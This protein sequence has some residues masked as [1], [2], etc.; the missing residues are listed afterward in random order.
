MAHKFGM[1]LAV[2]LLAT[3]SLT[4]MPLFEGATGKA[5]AQPTANQ[6]DSCT[7]LATSKLKAVTI[8][9]ATKIEAGAEVPKSRFNPMFGPSATVAKGLPAFCRV[10]G[11][12][13]PE[14]GSEIG[15]EVWF[16]QQQA[17]DG[18][19]HGI[20]IGGFAGVIDYFALGQAIKA[21]QVGVATNTGHNGS[22][23]DHGWAKGHPQRVT[24]Y[25][26]RAIHLSTVAAKQLTTAI[27]GRGPDKS[28]FVGCSGGGRQGLMQAAR[29]PEDYDGILAGAPAAN[30][31]ELAMALTNASQVQLSSGSEIRR[32]QMKFLQA[33][34]L[35]QCDA[36]D[37]QTDGL[38]ADPRQCRF[39]A[40]RLSC[41]TSKS[42]QCFSDPQLAALRRI[43]SGPKTS[44]GKQLAGGFLASGSESGLPAPNLGWEGYLSLE[45]GISGGR[46]LSDGFL[47]SLIQKPFATVETFN[48]DKHPKMLRVAMREI[49]APFDL[50]RFFTRGGKLLMWHGW[51]DAAIPPEATL[52][53]RDA[54]LRAS[55]TRAKANSQLFMIPGVQHCAGGA[56]PDSFGQ[57]GAPQSGDTPERSMVAALQA[58]TEGKRTAPQEFVGRRGHGDFMKMFGRGEAQPGQPER[59]RLLCAWPKTAM[60]KTGENPEL[61]A[62]YT[63]I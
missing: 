37:G 15:F 54:M 2:A 26:W 12:I 55:G 61:A 34:V 9:S 3:G 11:N 57:S 36:A 19:L 51:A 41:G 29:F 38:V 62:S 44:R 48:F 24:D 40:A 49:D 30:F 6:S 63:C 23:Q 53:Y 32:D 47:G 20:G 4:V 39:D 10:V 60:L 45:G 28:Y 46:I 22:M 21:G 52:R 31:S 5:F 42:T 13:S 1:G 16:P 14:P 50:R 56:G 17:W 18:R 58:W 33:E 27:Y 7:N 59:Q 25:A 35:Q 8:L 43:Q